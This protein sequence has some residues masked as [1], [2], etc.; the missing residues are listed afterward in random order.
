MTDKTKYALTFLGGAAVGVG[1]GLLF[2][3]KPGKETRED[4]KKK[5]A[6]FKEKGQEWLAKGKDALVQQKEQLG[7]AY[8]AGKEAYIEAKQEFVK[9]AN[10][11]IKHRE[12]HR[13]KVGV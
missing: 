5:L 9:P 12:L 1:I 8:V 11:P 6:E 2:A 3:P 13:E 4:V 7:A 10:G